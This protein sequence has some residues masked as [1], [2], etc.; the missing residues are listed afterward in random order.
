[1]PDA[2]TRPPSQD[3]DRLN[4]LERELDTAAGECA[5]WFG[6]LT[7]ARELVRR[8]RVE[9]DAYRSARKLIAEVEVLASRFTRDRAV[10]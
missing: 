4:A 9:G 3:Y 10:R 1:M 7:E 6:K 5:M 2:E 8:L